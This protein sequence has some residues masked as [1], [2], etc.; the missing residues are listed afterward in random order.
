MPKV[1]VIIPVYNVKDYIGECIES[2]MAQTLSEDME[3]ILIDDRGSDNSMEIARKCIADYNGPINFRYIVRDSNGG[4]SAAR[5]T[6]I[7]NATGEYVYFLDS[8]DIITPDCLR[9]L[10]ERANE[11][12]EAEIVCG[13][14]QSIPQKDVHKALSLQGKNFPNSS[15][16]K[17]WI[18][19]IFLSIYPVTA[20]NKLIRTDFITSNHL[21]FREGI[22]H[23]DNHW[24]AQAYHKV[25]GLAFVNKI[26]YLYRMR[27]GS[28]T[29]SE[30]VEE[31]RLNN[32]SLIYSEMF[33][34]QVKWDRPWTDWI[35]DS[36]N[37]LRYI[38]RK[39]NNIKRS[40]EIIARLMPIAYKNK[41]APLS[42]RILL[43][44]YTCNCFIY[45]PRVFYKLY[46]IYWRHK[47]YH[48]CHR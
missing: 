7:R 44:Y 30:G 14:F 25:S 40:E 21:F 15:F 45:R 12:P 36:V 26:T 2:V 41:T 13:D 43:R 1:S 8:D 32:L 37:I 4:L 39:A 18:R 28:I 31:R 48:S 16:D 46:D 10:V 23:E 24:H 20:W 22:L 47:R 17:V 6:G 34:K 38:G 5:N 11:Y 27:P 42:L 19:S 3:C 29:T 9:L 33:A 35:L